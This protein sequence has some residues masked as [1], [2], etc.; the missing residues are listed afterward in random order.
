MCGSAFDFSILCTRVY[1]AAY[2]PLAVVLTSLIKFGFDRSFLKQPLSE[3]SQSWLWIF[4]RFI[5]L[6]E[7]LKVSHPNSDCENAKLSWPWPI[8]ILPAITLPL[9]LAWL[10]IAAYRTIIGEHYAEL[11]LIIAFTWL[12]ATVRIVAFPSRTIMYDFFALSI[13]HFIGAAFHVYDAFGEGSG[14]RIAAIFNL[15]FIL[16]FFVIQGFMPFAVCSHGVTREDTDNTAGPED[17]TSLLAWIT[18]MWTYPIMRKG[19]YHT[20]NEDD[21]PNLSPTFQARPLFE[22]WL[23]AWDKYDPPP[24]THILE[25]IVFVDELTLQSISS[26]PIPLTSLFNSFSLRL[27]YAAS[28]SLPH[29]SSSKS[30]LDTID[31]TTHSDGTHKTAEELA[32]DR[33]RAY[34]YAFLLWLAIYF[35]AL[36]EVNHLWYGRRALTRTRSML[37][38]AIYDKA[39][40]RISI[41]SFQKR[42]ELGSGEDSTS[43]RKGADLGKVT[44]LM[45]AD[46][47]KLVEFLSAMF[48]L[49]D[50]PVGIT[51]AA[52]FLYKLLGWSAFAGLSVLLVGAP[53][54]AWL[55][56]RTIAITKNLTAARD[57]RMSVVT[58]VIQSIKFIKFFAWENKW[59]DRTMEKRAAEMNQ[60]MRARM[61]QV[62]YTLYWVSTPVLISVI[63]FTVFVA[64]G[65]TL[66]I[67]TAFTALQLFSIIRL[68]MNAL[69]KVL[70]QCFTSWVSLQRIAMYL[71][72]DEVPSFI[73]DVPGREEA[74]NESL[75]FD[76]ASFKWNK[77]QEN[78]SSA[79]SVLPESWP[80]VVKFFSRQSSESPSLSQQNDSESEPEVMGRNF[81]LKDISVT[82]P[83]EK[84]SIIV[85]PTASGK[86]AILMA[87][88]GEMTLLEGHLI[89]FSSK[90]KPTFAYASQ[91]PWLRHQTIKENI[92]FGYPLNESRYQDVVEACALNPDFETLEDGDR[93]E[94][95]SRGVSLSGGQKARVALARAVYSPAKYGDSV[96]SHTSR[97]L[98]EKLLCGP[99]LT[100][101]TVILVTHHVELVLPAATFFVRMLDGRIDAQGTVS[102]LRTRG[103]L[104]E[105]KHEMHSILQSPTAFMQEGALSQEPSHSASGVADTKSKEVTK[106]MAR[107]LVQDE[108]RQEGSVGLSVYNVYMKA[109]GYWVWSLVVSGV[110]LYQT[111]HH[112]EVWGS[113]YRVP[114][115]E[116]PSPFLDLAATDVGQTSNS[117][118]HIS[119]LSTPTTRQHTWPDAYKH[120]IYYIG[121]YAAIGFSGVLL[122]T[123]SALIQYY[124]AIQ[125]SKRLFSRLL[126][127]VMRATFRFH[128]TTP[129]GRLLNRF[130]KDIETIDDQLADMVW[131][132][133]LG[134]AGF[135]ASIIV[136]SVVFP[137]FLIPAMFIGFLYLQLTIGYLN[138]GRDLRRMEANTRSPI[139]STFSELLDGIVTVRA[140]SKETQFLEEFYGKVDL[141]T[142]MWY[143]FW[144]TNRFLLLNFDTLGAII[145]LIS[146]LL[147][148]SYL[149]GGAGLAGVCITSA[150]SF[151]AS[152]YWACRSYTEL[153]MCLNSV[154]RVVEYLD[155]P[156]EPPAVVENN[157]PPVYWPS[158]TK[159]EPLLTVEDLEIKYAPE[160]PSV[161][162][163]ISFRLKAGER[164][165][166]LGRTGSGKSTLA[167]SLFRFVDPTSG[168][169]YLDGIDI[170]DI[171]VYDLR[172]RMTFIPQDAS[173]FSGTIRDNLDPFGEHEDSECLDVLYR[174]HLL[175]NTATA[176]QTP[177][178]TASELFTPFPESLASRALVPEAKTSISLTTEVSAGGTNFS[179]GQRQLIALARALLRQ[180]SVVV[181]D[182]ATSSID[183]S[184]DTKIQQTIR[185][186]FSGALLITVAHRL[187]TIIDC[188]RLIVL[189]KGKIAEFDTPL[190]LIEKE[191]S[192]F[193]NMCLRSG[194][195]Q[196]LLEKARE[197]RELNT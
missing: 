17:Y 172:S 41:P 18:F 23:P 118:H 129:T 33:K 83:E 187:R 30:I 1:W 169:I 147:A 35:K 70:V 61:N 180:R 168:K 117:Y 27:V 160:L 24:L 195:F 50:N 177:S 5:T 154:E 182:E 74:L 25:P 125:A 91:V 184:T 6:E 44:N 76:H 81:E 103:L 101:R 16:A 47:N 9:T 134:I 197:S 37:M 67:G 89:H 96:D 65:H 82:F 176:S 45:S 144:M 98:F 12:Y 133:N 56:N 92:L 51:I 85:G 188:D 146:A 124:G 107:K 7:A 64:T 46:I 141:T 121:I 166:L 128:D 170:S 112:D 122:Q 179:Q 189:D 36:L 173:L 158:A 34:V 185:E 80:P 186:E 157:R 84:L 156:Q 42:D 196:E 90:T 26:N 137:V 115:E 59:I 58:E 174:T 181:L 10:G 163:G 31:T 116:H 77:I 175:A 75:G 164:V 13:A 167:M 109:S 88:L 155:L 66:T 110:I 93:T 119:L 165:G 71:N 171:G 127:T 57:A 105:M 86:T 14:S 113:A 55:S 4:S 28:I 68:P 62:F 99:L 192:I 111:T 94:I 136:I 194:S 183:F 102:E 132:T 135:S 43:P 69:P 114:V 8:R 145:T 3:R 53:L 52:V 149:Q 38:T 54:N 21:I 39:L 49:Y 151:Y 63:S 143:T 29:S 150:M 72:E 95:G 178:Q 159:N 191:G 152:V 87:L 15:F 104:D 78:T 20:L 73:V 120:P 97:F 131:E 32:V 139:F 106:S 193:R 19:R 22:K 126:V 60:I 79:P 11:F 123:A 2:L 100:N 161:L 40:K 138:T 140:F 108:Y 190:A 142:K 130:G 48:F 153:E 162:Q 148:I